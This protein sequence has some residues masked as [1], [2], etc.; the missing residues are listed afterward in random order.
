GPLRFCRLVWS[1]ALPCAYFA[2]GGWFTGTTFVTSWYTHGLASSYLEGCN[3]LT[4]AVSTPANSLAAFFVVTVGTRRFYSLVS[5][6]RSVAFVALHGA[7]ALIG[8]MLRQFELARSVQLRPYK[9]IAFSGP[10]AVFVSVFLIYP[11]GQSGGSLRLVLGV[12]AIFRFILFFQGNWFM[13]ECSWSSRSS[14][15]PTYSRCG[16]RLKISLMKNLIFP[17]EVLPRGNALN[18]TLALA[19]RDQ[20]PLVSL[21]GRECPTY[22]FI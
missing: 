16:W 19:G 9:A 4:A 8:F 11:L 15:E 14:F 12:A 10:I 6:R 21:G 13:D 18:G 17:E 20:K 7:F 22:Q 2:L 5:I 3:F 1:I